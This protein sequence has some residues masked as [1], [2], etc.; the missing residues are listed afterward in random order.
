M[1]TRKDIFGYI[2]TLPS[3][4]YDFPFEGDFNSAVLRH[5]DTGKWFGL[6]LNVPEKYF[7]G[8]GEG[9]NLK[10]PEDLAQILTQRYV[11]V[12]PAYHMNKKLWITVM[13]CAD[14]PEDEIFKL[15]QLSFD[16]TD[17]KR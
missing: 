14:V 10:C 3:A 6:I 12:I 17:K 2:K 1:V 13:F 5:K 7:K 15:I 9:V 8:G 11:G 4:G 16:I